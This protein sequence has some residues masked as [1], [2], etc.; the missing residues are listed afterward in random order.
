[1]ASRTSTV[2]AKGKGGL[3]YHNNSTTAQ[4]VTINA[5]AQ[6]GV[7][8]P[9]IGVV[10]SNSA[11][12]LLNQQVLQ[13]SLGTSVHARLMD[14]DVTN[15]GQSNNLVSNTQHGSSN[16]GDKDGNVYESSAADESSHHY[17]DPWFW[18]KP[19]DYGNAT[20][21][22]GVL[23]ATSSSN[24]PA[25]WDDAVGLVNTNSK[26]KHSF[27]NASSTDFS[28]H[29]SMSY[30]N[31]VIICDQ[32]T[33]VA[34]SVNTNGYMTEARFSVG[35]A[36]TSTGNATS[37]SA[38]YG[39]IIQN[40][41]D[42]WSYPSNPISGNQKYSPP[43]QADAGVFA[44][45]YQRPGQ[46]YSFVNISAGGRAAHNGVLPTNH[47]AHTT[48]DWN[49]SNNT[50]AGVL[51]NGDMHSYFQTSRGGLQWIKWNPSTD[52]Y[53]IC[54]RDNGGTS[55][56][57]GIWAA[58][59]AKITGNS[60]NNINTT[61]G[62]PTGSYLHNQTAWE[63][64]ADYPLDDVT[65]Y[66]AMPARVGS[67]LWVSW[68]LAS[69]APYFSED[70]VTWKTQAQFLD[71]GFKLKAE[72]KDGVEFFVKDNNEVIVLSTGLAEMNQAGLLEK[73]TAV[74]NY[75]RNGLVVNP[76]DAI[77]ADV[78]NTATTSVSF[79]VMDVGI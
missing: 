72:N 47:A 11:T 8:N 60:N 20:D 76:G 62:G 35:S 18:V 73:D 45:N 1:M 71:S 52:I 43:A 48:G 46:S 63:R 79:T 54:L 70:L 14:I 4:L 2:V 41:G 57:A 51:A 15:G 6:D 42:P 77:Y 39:N 13:Y 74:G 12:E 24:Y 32:Y 36:T 26:T 10:L 50:G 67:R 69:N 58:P 75:T 3:I 21:S 16:M 56:H 22:K 5:V 25:Q 28:R 33:Q 61:G 34:L 65:S 37:N 53:Y 38:V 49:T 64:V 7:S 17:V 27:F 9:K 78:E 55:N 23:L 44:F 29:V 30:S 40:G 31:R 66:M 59:W 19:S 68:N